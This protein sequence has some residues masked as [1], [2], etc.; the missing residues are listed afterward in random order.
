[1]SDK[2]SQ[3]VKHEKSARLKY[4][5]PALVALEQVSSGM[6]SS[7]YE[8]GN[9]C[10]NGE[11]DGDCWTGYQ[12]SETCDMGNEKKAKAA[13]NR[14][15]KPSLKTKA[16]KY[17]SKKGVELGGGEGEGPS[18]DEL[19]QSA[20][21]AMVAEKYKDAYDLAKQSNKKKGSAKTKQLMG[22]AACK[23]KSKK[24]ATAVAKKLKGGKRDD[25]VKA[26]ADNG[27]E[28]ELE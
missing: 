15:S 21:D 20:R 3:M 7:G 22:L 1:M 5:K 10:E 16:E 27:I 9:L 24:K 2:V 8:A 12:A 18:A 25:V 6:C 19:L 26:C 17:C 28:L 23:M 4:E 11:A 13:L 14:V